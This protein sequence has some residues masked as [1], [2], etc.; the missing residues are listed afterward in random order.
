MTVVAISAALLAARSTPPRSPVPVTIALM[1]FAGAA[2]PAGDRIL[3]A[4]TADA[5]ELTIVGPR[6]TAPLFARTGSIRDV[7][8]ATA[9]DLLIHCKCRP[10]NALVEIIR[11]RDGKHLWVRRYS[12]PILAS[13][14]A[15]ITAAALAVAVDLR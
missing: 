3:E 6:T 2:E 13:D 11:A 14:A 12:R 9:A 10:R 4:L 1:P 7:A 15:E 8:S 5:P